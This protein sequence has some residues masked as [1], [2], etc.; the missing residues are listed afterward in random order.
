VINKYDREGGDRLRHDI[1][2]AMELTDWKRPGGWLPFVSPAIA[3]R[4]E[5]IA[6][7]L[8]SAQRHRDWLRSDA[9]RLGAARREK[10]K[11]RLRLLLN[12][13]LLEQAWRQTGF[14]EK[15]DG[16]LERIMARELSPYQWVESVMDR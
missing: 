4:E 5:G 10:A 14:E 9:Q 16:A 1:T 15:L 11:R 7:I 3:T 8:E 13:M 6:E 2:V 12:R